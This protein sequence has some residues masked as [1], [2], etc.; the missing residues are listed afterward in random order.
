MLFQLCK[1]A[2][3]CVANSAALEYGH[4]PKYSTHVMV[5]IVN[6]FK[7]GLNHWVQHFID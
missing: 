2:K 1:F 7:P 5:P 3:E 4:L 6:G